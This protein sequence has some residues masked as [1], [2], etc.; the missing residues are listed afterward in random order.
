MPGGSAADTRG[1]PG[2][3]RDRGHSDWPVPRHLL[4]RER[5]RRTVKIPPLTLAQWCPMLACASS[6]DQF[7][8]ERQSPNSSLLYARAH[9]VIQRTQV[10][11]LIQVIQVIQLIQ[12]SL[13]IH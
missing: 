10:I 1:H 9:P 4:R 13:A 3:E 12:T 8:D 6:R 5:T 11:Q 7:G 2:L